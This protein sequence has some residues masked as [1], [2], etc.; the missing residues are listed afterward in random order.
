MVGQDPDPQPTRPPTEEDLKRLCATLNAA[1]AK[2]LVI[3]GF[4]VNY[5]GFARGT[6]DLDLMI[7]SDPDNVRRIRQALCVLPDHAAQDLDPSDFNRY[8]VIR[9]VD[10]ITVDL[11]AQIG[12]VSFATAR[13]VPVPLGDVTIPIADLPTLIATKQGVRE[14]D[15]RDLAYLLLLQAKLK[16]D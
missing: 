13:A 12:E 5:Y 16:E 15:Q 14:R 10:E 3:G 9:I 4:A 11:I 7:A 1:G 8:Q 2:Y 6:E